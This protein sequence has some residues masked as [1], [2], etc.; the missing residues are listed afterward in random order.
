MHIIA[1]STLKAFWEKHNDAEIP[2]KTWHKIVEKERWKNMQNIK[3]LFG[4]ASVISNSRVVFNI[5][6][7]DYRL[8]VYIIF[9]LERVYIRFI[10]T[11]NQYDKIDA[12]TI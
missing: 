4:N 5:K 12:K 10:G 3:K 9:K 11:H 1:K 2:L 8:V 6:G 7:N